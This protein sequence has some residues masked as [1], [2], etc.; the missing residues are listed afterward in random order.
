MT[1]FSFK[2]DQTLKQYTVV[3]AIVVLYGQ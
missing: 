3:L 2:S 1:E